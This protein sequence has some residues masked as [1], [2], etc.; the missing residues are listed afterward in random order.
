MW[1]TTVLKR[2]I[3]DTMPGDPV[4][5]VADSRSPSTTSHRRP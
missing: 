5:E 3:V 2:D 1:E 4:A